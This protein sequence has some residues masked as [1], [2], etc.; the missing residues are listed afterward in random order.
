MS[1]IMAKYQEVE[2]RN[3]ARVNESIVA[4]SDVPIHIHME[5][6]DEEFVMANISIKAKSGE[7]FEHL[8]IW[9][10]AGEPDKRPIGEKRKKY[11]LKYHVA[12][13]GLKVVEFAGRTRGEITNEFDEIHA[14]F[15]GGMRLWRASNRC[16]ILNLMNMK[17]KETV[18]HISSH[19]TLFYD[20]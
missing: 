17:R 5:V 2:S 14:D 12:R 1:M 7:W 9:S 8:R 18:L 20:L 10:G 19:A 6:M 3:G 4:V 13:D 15:Y 16:I 11:P